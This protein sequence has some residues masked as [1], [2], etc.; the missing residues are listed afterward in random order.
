LEKFTDSNE[1]KFL[2]IFKS[3]WEKVS[4]GRRKCLMMSLIISAPHPILLNDEM[5]K[6]ELGEGYSMH[7]Q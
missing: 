6:V 5:M 1:K 4:R 2:R 3:K 7:G